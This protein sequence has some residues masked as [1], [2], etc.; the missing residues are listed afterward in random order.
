VH[1]GP[2]FTSFAALAHMSTLSLGIYLGY[3]ISEWN[4]M[5]K[6]RTNVSRTL[7]DRI[8]SNED[9]K[10]RENGEKGDRVT[11]EQTQQFR[12]SPDLEHVA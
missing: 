4:G 7:M 5:G 10:K 6:K 8:E 9:E 1:N 11:M 12:F 3:S 2:L